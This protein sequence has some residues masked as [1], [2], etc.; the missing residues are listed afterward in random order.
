MVRVCV[1][2]A[3]DGVWDGGGDGGGA[4]F[5]QWGFKWCRWSEFVLVMPVVE[6]EMV[7]VLEELMVTLSRVPAVGEVVVDSPY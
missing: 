3:G 6:L 1:S 2:D 7:L 4:E 5:W